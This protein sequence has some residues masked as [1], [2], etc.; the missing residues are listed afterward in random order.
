MKNEKGFND[1][2]ELHMSTKCCFK[3][4]DSTFCPKSSYVLSISLSMFGVA[5]SPV[6]YQMELTSL[7]HAPPR[8]KEWAQDL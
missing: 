7:S 5:C 3:N 6:S 8:V 1:Q 2:E 4:R